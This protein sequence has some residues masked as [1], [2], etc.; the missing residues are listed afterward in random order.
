MAAATA[1]GS[2]NEKGYGRGSWRLIGLLFAGTA[3]IFACGIL[4][5]S[6]F[7]GLDQALA[8][9]LYPFIPGLILKMA[10]AYGI[11]RVIRKI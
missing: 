2:I 11:V 9:G 8:S 3:I 7:T 6:F 10:L 1:M 4:W 5:L